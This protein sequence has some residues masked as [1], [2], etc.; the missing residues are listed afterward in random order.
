[1]QVIKVLCA[2]API[3]L[4]AACTQPATPPAPVPFE[5]FKLVVTP[6]GKAL[7]LDSQTGEVALITDKGV[8][9]L[10][11]NERI[12]LE[13]GQLYVS[14]TGELFAYEGKLKFGSAT[15]ALLKKYG[16]DKKAP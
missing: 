15:E 1:M 14:E 3:W 9:T 6:D 4:L 13:V 16:T 11:T 5:K 8:R 10:P 12:R 7:R 2:V